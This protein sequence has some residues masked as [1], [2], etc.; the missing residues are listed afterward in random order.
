MQAIQQE[1][2]APK[3][4]AHYTEDA[5]IWVRYCQQT[6]NIPNALAVACAGELQSMLKSERK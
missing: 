2:Q 6:I 5:C 1:T 3:Q 4:R